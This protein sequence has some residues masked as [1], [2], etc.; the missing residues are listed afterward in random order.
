MVPLQ[1]FAHISQL[2]HLQNPVLVLDEE[3]SIHADFCLDPSFPLV[4][5]A[6]D[7][8]ETLDYLELRMPGSVVLL[9]QG[10]HKKLLV[11]LNNSQH[12]F[13][14]SNLWVI[15]LEHERAIPLRL[16]SRGSIQLNFSRLFNETFNR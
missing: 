3:E 12:L 4:C 10:N 9:S 1:L 6:S 14:K 5:V 15:P 8:G 13:D 16:D 2:V 11:D 7:S